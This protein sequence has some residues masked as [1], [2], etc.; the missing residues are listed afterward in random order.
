MKVL[1][2]RIDNE[3]EKTLNFLMEHKKIIDKSAYL[4]QMMEKSL[5]SDLLDYLC[6][7]VEKHNI[8][9]WKAA[10]IAQISLR[11]MLHEL[12]LRKIALYEEKDFLD[13]LNMLQRL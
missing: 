10:E 2:I 1:S 7:E 11:R 8:T 9:A 4:R 12:K 6:S 3:F 13:D 5:Q